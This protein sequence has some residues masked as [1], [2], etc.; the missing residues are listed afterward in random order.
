MFILNT[1]NS[2]IAYVKTLKK[3]CVIIERLCCNT[4]GFFYLNNIEYSQNIYI[5]MF[6]HNT[7]N[8]IAYVKGFISTTKSIV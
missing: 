7:R 2:N 5:E 4:E 1:R 8:N 6:I 3:D